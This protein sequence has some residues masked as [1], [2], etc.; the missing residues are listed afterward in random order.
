MEPDVLELTAVESDLV[1]E[2]YVQVQLHERGIPY[3]LGGLAG[4]AAGA[5]SWHRAGYDTPVTVLLRTIHVPTKFAP[6]MIHVRPDKVE[7]AAGMII[8]DPEIHA[9][10]ETHRC[11][12]Y[13]TRVQGQRPIRSFVKIVPMVH[14]Q[15]PGRA[16]ER[17]WRTWAYIVLDSF[18]LAA[19]EPVD[20]DGHYA[21]LMVARWAFLFGTALYW[22]EQEHFPPPPNQ[23]ADDLIDHS[24]RHTLDAA[25]AQVLVGAPGVATIDRWLTIF[26]A[27]SVAGAADWEMAHFGAQYHALDPITPHGRRNELK[28]QYRE[29]VKSLRAGLYMARDRID[30][31]AQHHFASL[32][33]SAYEPQSRTSTRR[34]GRNVHS[35]SS[36][37]F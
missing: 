23:S 13:S 5:E 16:G 7:D 29:I 31:H 35:Q 36:S 34:I 11:R 19:G 14:P 32:A 37:T 2:R 26:R 28:G 21:A 15:D 1:T 6:I 3:A 12:W 20:S 17:N 8:Y 27:D 9:P 24:L 4:L 33:K 25:M 10:F 22:V 30:P 18:E